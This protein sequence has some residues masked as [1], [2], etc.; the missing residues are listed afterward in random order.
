MKLVLSGGY[1]KSDESI[2]KSVWYR[3]VSKIAQ[4]KG[5]GK[6]VGIIT[7]ARMVGYYD[8]FVGLYREY[9]IDVV[10]R[11]T[12]F[13]E[14]SKYDFLMLLG[15]NAYELFADLNK[16]GMSFEKLKSDAEVLGDSAGA[17]M[18][19]RYFFVSP[20]GVQRGRVVDFY[21]GFGILENTIV[22]GHSDNEAFTN[23]LLVSKVESFAEQNRLEIIY[24][25]ENQEVEFV[26]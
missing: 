23:E 13:V 4:L 10:D 6:H 16:K 18:F 17:Y 19:G 15:G 1:N 11:E 9:N 7:S 20:S 3:Y 26:L 12:D 14:W 25:N 2:A 22:V 5:N 21:D 24:I 8:E